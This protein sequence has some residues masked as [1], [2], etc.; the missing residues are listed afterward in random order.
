M[1]KRHLPELTKTKPRHAVSQRLLGAKG[2]VDDFVTYGHMGVNFEGGVKLGGGFSASKVEVYVDDIQWY[3]GPNDDGGPA[4]TSPLGNNVVS[5]NDFVYPE[6]Y[7]LAI[8]L[9]QDDG[10][11][12]RVDSTDPANPNGFAI[13][14][15]LPLYFAVNDVK[16]TYGDNWGSYKVFI[17]I[18][19]S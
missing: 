5:G 3:N 6:F 18:L 7:Q 10:T 9:R 8:V 1:M 4:I 17:K 14:P 15:S 16:G 2:A 19:A 11:V 12:Q 13:E